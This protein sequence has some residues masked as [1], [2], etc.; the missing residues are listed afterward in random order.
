[1]RKPHELLQLWYILHTAWI[2]PALPVPLWKCRKQRRPQC[3]RGSGKSCRPWMG[4]NK[5]QMGAA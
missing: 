1:M 2:L 4:A 5:E 3:K